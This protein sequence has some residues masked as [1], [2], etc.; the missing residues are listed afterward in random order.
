MDSSTVMAALG[1]D[2]YRV[3]MSFGSPQVRDAKRRVSLEIDNLIDT[4]MK[5]YYEHYHP[6]RWAPKR[7][8]KWF[9]LVLKNCPCCV[10]HSLR[11][12]MRHTDLAMNYPRN[13]NRVIDCPCPCRMILRGFL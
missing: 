2:L 9:F 4:A 10:R 3:I 1:I 5:T 8:R 11:R 6:R 7:D 13:P 12:P